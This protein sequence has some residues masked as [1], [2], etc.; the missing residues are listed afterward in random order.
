MSTRSGSTC[1]SG[2]SFSVSLFSST[3]VCSAEPVCV[4]CP[5]FVS[6]GF[7]PVSVQ[8]E[9]LCVCDMNS[10]LI[11]FP[12]IL[13]VSSV[14]SHQVYKLQK[15]VVGHVFERLLLAA[16]SLLFAP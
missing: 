7:S 4:A 14:Q 9:V 2:C 5:S 15:T 8:V 6:Q 1:V 3:T 10:F 16:R 13:S 12:Q 11:S